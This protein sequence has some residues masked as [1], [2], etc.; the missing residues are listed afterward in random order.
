MR[1]KNF[2]AKSLTASWP[3]LFR[4]STS[5]VSTAHQDVDARHKAG[6]DEKQVNPLDHLAEGVTRHLVRQV[7]G[8]IRFAIPPHVLGPS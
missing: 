3:D 5:S 6:H 4:P 7:N 2:D 8:G 1:A